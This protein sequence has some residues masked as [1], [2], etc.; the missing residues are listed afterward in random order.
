MICW[1]YF[2]F[3]YEVTAWLYIHEDLQ[4]F[5]YLTTFF[6]VHFCGL[7]VYFLPLYLFTTIIVFGQK[8]CLRTF[9]RPAWGV[10]L[11]MKFFFF[12]YCHYHC[13]HEF[14]G[15]PLKQYK[16]AMNM[17]L[18]RQILYRLEAYLLCLWQRQID[19]NESCKT[20]FKSEVCFMS[21]NLL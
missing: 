18:W 5:T 14:H 11:I 12:L 21:A 15:M 17:L 4:V 10:L 20:V 19:D 8:L 2:N 3:K 1:R 6:C 9:F 16:A 7:I 13:K